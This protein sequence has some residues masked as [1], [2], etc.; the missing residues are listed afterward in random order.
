MRRSGIPHLI[1]HHRTHHLHR[2]RH[3]AREVLSCQ[4]VL[5]RTAV[6]V[7]L[8]GVVAWIGKAF[9]WLWIVVVAVIVISVVLRYA[10]HHSSIVMEELQW[11]LASAVWLSGLA[12]TLAADE[13]VRVD[14]LRERMSTETQAW[15]E[16]AGILLLFLPFVGIAFY[17]AAPYFLHSVEHN[18]RSL[19]PGGMPWRWAIKVFLP[20]SFAL[21]AIA[22]LARLT[23]C[24]ALLFGFPKPL[25][26][27]RD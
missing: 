19:S 24:T 12:Y 10:F 18:E 25:P 2:H 27:I 4:T 14:V 21:L 22:G 7:A 26:A 16:L 8:D 9:S 15:I 3:V 5:P 20:L 13:H 23:R 11:H 17:E 1:G 6:S